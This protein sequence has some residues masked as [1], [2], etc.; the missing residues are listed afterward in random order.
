MD[1]A[2][3]EIQL[4]DKGGAAP[5][6]SP[7]PFSASPNGGGSPPQAGIADAWQRLRNT[8]PPVPV[9]PPTNAPASPFSPLSFTPPPLAASPQIMPAPAT[10]NVPKV[11]LADDP[12]T[13][14]LRQ[15]NAARQRDEVEAAKRKILGQPEPGQAGSSASGKPVGLAGM[16]QVDA[17]KIGE[18]A[19]GAT[20]SLMG[21]NLGGAVSQIGSL[22]PAAGAAGKSLAAVAGPVGI[23]VAAVGAFTYGVKRASDQLSE[24]AE[25]LKG[26]S[27][28]LATASAQ[29]DAAQAMGDIR[30]AE[31][32]G[33]EL[34]QFVK[35]R[36][37]LSQQWQDFTNQLERMLIP[38]VKPIL[39]HLSMILD[40]I[41]KG[42]D[43]LD[44]RAPEWRDQLA[45]A[46]K[47]SMAITNPIL[48]IAIIADYFMKKAQ[49]D[50]SADEG[51]TLE[52][53]FA[54]GLGTAPSPIDPRT[55][56]IMGIQNRAPIGVLR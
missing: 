36:S 52:K 55:E 56:E 31:R 28:P 47:W 2:T 43:Y 46:T 30:R 48:R 14:A 18:G 26:F 6:S 45:S 9:A 11:T 15:I 21:G 25:L 40:R 20:Q 17:Q 23:A 37:D 24:T 41:N 4:V 51:L 53:F 54:A 49:K 5:A 16:P 35:A 3:L 12:Y 29:A 34:A 1:R 42:F 27:A 39:Q 33:P 50:E 13:L 38:I 22:A 32:S 19:V 10:P 44:E 8:P 7:A